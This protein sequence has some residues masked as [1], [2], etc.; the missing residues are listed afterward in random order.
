MHGGAL[1]LAVGVALFDVF[2]FVELDFAFADRE[3]D[4]HFAVFPIEGERK[5]SV[6]FHGGVAEELANFGFVK[7]E[8][9]RRFWIVVQQVAVA[10][11]VDVRV[12][13]EDLVIIDAREGVADLAFAGA[14]G[15]DLGAL[16]DDSR[17][18]GLDDVVIAPSFWV[19]EDFGVG[20]KRIR[21]EGKPS[22]RK[23]R[24]CFRKVSGACA[25]WGP[26]RVAIPPGDRPRFCLRGFPS[27]QCQPHPGRRFR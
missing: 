5:E 16:E 11:F 17:L 13:E 22:G 6:A 21:P 10:V 19:G 12:V 25:F 9:A 2:A 15:L 20:H 3:G 24:A 23:I 26:R 14:E 7:K 4:F 27:E 8:F 18:V 1:E